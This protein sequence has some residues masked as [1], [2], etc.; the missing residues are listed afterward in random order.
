MSKL[1]WLIAMN[2]PCPR[3]D[4]TRQRVERLL[5]DPCYAAVEFKVIPY[6]D[7]A[8]STFA[9]TLNKQV[10]TARDVAEKLNLTVDWDAFQKLRISPEHPS[11]DFEL[12]TG[13]AR[14]WSPD[15]DE[16]L[17]QCEQ[18]ADE[19]GILMTPILV[20]DGVLKHTGS[21]VTVDQLKQWLSQES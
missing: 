18:K 6:N 3:G 1:I 19:A 7:Q 14:E 21:V 20:V 4:A 5:A 9:T 8:A 17:R 13:V 12:F 16:I 10:G 11:E 2:P 15:L